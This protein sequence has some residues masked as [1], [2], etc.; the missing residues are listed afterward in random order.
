MVSLPAHV[1]YI[2]G[3]KS[4]LTQ[5]S[6]WGLVLGFSLL[7]MNVVKITTPL[8]TRSLMINFLNLLATERYRI[9]VHILENASCA[10]KL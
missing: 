7:F 4:G 3:H 6:V 9:W 2:L 5:E 10:L 1:G 8:V